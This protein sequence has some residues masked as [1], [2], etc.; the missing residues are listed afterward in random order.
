VMSTAIFE[1][2]CHS[3]HHVRLNSI[4]DVI[5]LQVLR[6]SGEGYILKLSYCGLD[7]PNDYRI[8]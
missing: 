4:L 3:C 2:L 8:Y 1:L 7:R 5:D 6:L